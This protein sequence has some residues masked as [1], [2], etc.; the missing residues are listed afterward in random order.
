MKGCL[1][2]RVITIPDEKAGFR[3]TGLVIEEFA[4][5]L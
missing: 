3:D 5:L 2:R 1:M 4:E